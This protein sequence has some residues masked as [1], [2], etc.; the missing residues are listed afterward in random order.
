MYRA[1]T[2]LL[3]VLLIVASPARAEI[4][5]LSDDFYAERPLALIDDPLEPFNR[6][7]FVIND[8]M[9]DWLARPVSVAYAAVLPADLRG[10]VNN[11][12]H[13]LEEPVRLVNA[14]LQ[15]RVDEARRVVLRF[16]V[17]SIVGV[18]GL[19]DPAAREFGLA[20]VDASLD[21]TLA[22][23]GLGYGAYLFV[24]L[25]GPGTVRELG[26]TTLEGF[27]MPY[28]VWTEEA[29]QQAGVYL[30]KE[31]NDLSLRIDEYDEVR[32][33]TLDPYLAVRNAYAQ[34][35]AARLSGSAR[36]Q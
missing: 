17:N 1:L 31:F 7:M 8:T 32:R 36:T 29:L 4:D 23:W 30:G 16:F 35:H 19:G 20:P 10:C 26:A 3:F 11:F 14:L 22:R 6:V 2:G 24:P 34:Y 33:L 25:W 5:V 27:A 13:N 15:G 21:E 28:Y 12:F 9:Y 18:Y